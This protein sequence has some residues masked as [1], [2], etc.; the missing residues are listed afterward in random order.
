[1]DRI[2]NEYF[3]GTA[4]VKRVKKTRLEKQVKVG[5]GTYRERKQL[6]W[7]KNNA[8]DLLNKRKRKNI[9]RRFVNAIKDD[10]KLDQIFGGGCNGPRKMAKMIYC[11]H[12]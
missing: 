6:Y 5:C 4:H 10:I 2:R 11:A 7:V 12:V 9:K 1:M 3:R 8:M